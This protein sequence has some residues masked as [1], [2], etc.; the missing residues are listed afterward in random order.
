MGLPM[1]YWFDRGK[2]QRQKNDAQ[3][4]QFI[5]KLLYFGLY[6]IGCNPAARKIC[7]AR[8]R[9]RA[10]GA[11]TVESPLIILIFLNSLI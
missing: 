7:S 3:T 10:Q 8:A 1:A 2:P 4:G 9:A 6:I 11:R 5:T